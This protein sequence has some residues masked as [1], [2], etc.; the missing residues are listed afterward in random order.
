MT[1]PQRGGAVNSTTVTQQP[2]QH[3]SPTSPIQNEFELLDNFWLG[4]VNLTRYH[5]CAL[6]NV[7]LNWRKH[8]ETQDCE[9]LRQ[10]VLNVKTF[11]KL[12]KDTNNYLL[13]IIAYCDNF[14]SKINIDSLSE[15]EESLLSHKQKVIYN[16]LEELCSIFE[17]AENRFCELQKMLAICLSAPTVFENGSQDQIF[18]LS[19][20]LKWLH[21]TIY[22]VVVPV[23]NT[24]GCPSTE[25]GL[26][27]VS[28]DLV[29]VTDNNDQ[30]TKSVLYDKNKQSK[31][32]QK[33]KSKTIKKHGKFLKLHSHRL[34]KMKHKP[35]LLERVRTHMSK[36]K[37]TLNTKL[38]KIDHIFESIIGTCHTIHQLQCKW[39]PQRPKI[40]IKYK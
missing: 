33:C 35:L 18:R 4:L 11:T 29:T 21:P 10:T 25:L 24:I 36:K 22:K 34:H 31:T 27:S 17:K 30:N 32:K 9:S 2:P 38:L 15:S 40:K 28:C 39:L 16:Q 19:Q 37:K 20:N 5:N 1:P 14:S 23:N 3:T 8:L 13:E 26:S 7:N 12:H 6:L